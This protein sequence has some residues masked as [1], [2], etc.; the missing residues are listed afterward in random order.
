MIRN[1]K[2]LQFSYITLGKLYHLRDSCAEEALWNEELR[3][4]VV[5]GI[6]SQIEKIEREVR[7]YLAKQDGRDGDRSML[8]E[9]EVT[10]P[11]VA[12]VA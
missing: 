1:E 12:K 3:A 9:K 7:E 6:E 4:D 10:P 8:P 5:V 11:E 2:E